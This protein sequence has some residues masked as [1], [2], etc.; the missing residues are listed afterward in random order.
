MTRDE[1][2]TAYKEGKRDFRGADLR[3]TNLR[4]EDLCCANLYG[5]NLRGAD[6]RGANLRDADLRGANLRGAY[7]CGA[8]LR[9]ANLRDANLRG[10]YLCGANFRDANLRGANLRDADLCG[11]DL[12]AQWVIQGAIR[13][14]D[15]F[16]MFTSLTNEGPRIKAGCRNFTVVEAI[17]HWQTTRGGTQLGEE[18]LEIVHHLVKLAKIRGYDMGDAPQ[19]EL[20]GCPRCGQQG[21]HDCPLSRESKMEDTP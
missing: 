7:L 13:S 1:L 18:S 14:D 2:L 15:Y 6:L 12:G 10:A 17:E 4:D 5:A 20:A 3:G 11:A 8:N 21:E 19:T 16:F 9:D